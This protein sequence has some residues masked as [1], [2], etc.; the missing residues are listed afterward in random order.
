M[1]TERIRPTACTA[2][3][4]DSGR[5][6][7]SRTI[8]GTAILF[9]AMAAQSAP[10]PP[11]SCVQPPSGAQIVPTREFWPILPHAVARSLANPLTPDSQSVLTILALGDSAVWGNG[12]KNQHKYSY[13]V[14]QSMADATGRRV[15]LVAYAHSGALLATVDNAGYVP[16]IKADNGRPAGDL[17]ASLPSTVQQE[18]CAHQNPSTKDAEIVLV[19]GCINDV[20]AE[21]IGLPYPLS[22]ATKEEIT[23]LTQQRCSDAMLSLL[24]TTTAEFSHATVIV[25][26]YWRIISDKSSPVGI[27]LTSRVPDLSESQRAMRRDV[28][29]Y[30]D[31]ERRAE[32]I[33][34]ELITDESLYS[35][36][37]ALFGKW[38]DNSQAFLESSQRCFS[39]A[40]A[41]VDGLAPAPTSPVGGGPCPSVNAP[42]AQRVSMNYRV[43]LAVVPDDQNFAYG[44]PMKHLWSIPLPIPPSRK[45][46]VYDKRAGMCVTHFFRPE[47]VGSLFICPIDPTGHPNVLGAE[48]YHESTMNFLNV[49]W[50]KVVK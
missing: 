10:V 38:S 23:S 31:F 28:L 18:G 48:A 47:D 8:A 27:A 17:N 36:P 21:K 15:R 11:S 39:W 46:E 35:Q 14:A 19:N 40:T 16:L 20:S 34:R 24:Q 12:L 49:A 5:G 30:M 13:E 3:R 25:A 22:G 42:A 33:T 2:T 26:N 4:A 44:A 41:V 6:T 43:F 50:Q 32:Q 7:A 9:I 45:D 1:S 29:R 37:A